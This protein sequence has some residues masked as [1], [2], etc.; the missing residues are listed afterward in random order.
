MLKGHTGNV[1]TVSC[2]RP[3][4]KP[5][6]CGQNSL[7]Y[8][9]SNGSAPIVCLRVSHPTCTPVSLFAALTAKEYLKI[10]GSYNHVNLGMCTQ[11]VKLLLPVPPPHEPKRQVLPRGAWPPHQPHTLGT[12]Q[13]HVLNCISQR[14]TSLLKLRPQTDVSRSC[15]RPLHVH[16]RSNS[17]MMFLLSN[18]INEMAGDDRLVDPAC[19][20]QYSCNQEIKKRVSSFGA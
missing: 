16:S 8:L 11:W 9:E 20:E 17:E 3:F 15:A 18:R 14:F 1:F 2:S 12:L 7:V 10:S 6:P 19:Q 4:R 5:D 13:H